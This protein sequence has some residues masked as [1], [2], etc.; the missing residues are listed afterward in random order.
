ML[1][2]LPKD[3]SAKETVDDPNYTPSNKNTSRPNSRSSPGAHNSLRYEVRVPSRGSQIQ[4]EI[5]GLEAAKEEIAMIDEDESLSYSKIREELK[6]RE[7]EAL[8]SRR[9]TM[10]KSESTPSM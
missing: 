3:Q 4:A 6:S 5:D 7:K 2:S 1:K 9:H 8:R 10:G